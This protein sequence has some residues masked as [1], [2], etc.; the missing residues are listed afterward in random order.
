M[1][2]GMWGAGGGGILAD[3]HDTKTPSATVAIIE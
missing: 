1:L 2:W 3:S